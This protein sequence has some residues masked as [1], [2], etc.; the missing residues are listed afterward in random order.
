MDVGG[1][2]YTRECSSLDDGVIEFCIQISPT[3]T[4]RA[5]K[6]QESIMRNHTAITTFILLGLTE[7]PQLQLLLFLFLFLTYILSVAGNLTI[8]TLTLLDP[9]LKTPMYFFLQNFS[10]L[11]ISFM[12]ACFPRF[13][14]SLSTGDRIIT[15]NACAIQLFFIDLFGLMEFFLL[16]TIASDR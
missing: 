12:I 6:I 2:E 5:G 11:G 14:Y 9:H 1:V 15:Y 7:D 8:I 3:L 13:L 16:A 4:C 10:F